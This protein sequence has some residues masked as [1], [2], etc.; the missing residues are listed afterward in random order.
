MVNPETAAAV[1]ATCRRGV[2]HMMVPALQIGPHR[3]RLPIVQGG[4]GIGVSRSGLAA[5]VA[6]AGGVGVLASVGLG[7]LRKGLQRDF[8]SA[9]CRVLRAELGAPGKPPGPHRRQRHDRRRRSQRP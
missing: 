8:V 9:N 4:M 5:A 6:E 3:A 1:M 7:A 2:A